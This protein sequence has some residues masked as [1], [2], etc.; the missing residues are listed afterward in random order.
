MSATDTAV[1]PPTGVW[2]EAENDVIPIPAITS[3]LLVGAGLP[4]DLFKTPAA[5]YSGL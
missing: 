4:S 5:D 1:A 3:N 2:I